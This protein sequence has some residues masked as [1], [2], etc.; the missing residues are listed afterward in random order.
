MVIY[1]KAYAT[2]KSYIAHLPSGGEMDIP[3]ETTVNEVLTMLKVPVELDK[4]IIV[5][6]RHQPLDYTLRHGDRLVFFPLI[7][8]G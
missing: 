6:N 3:E 2:M 5:N 7:Q 1:I 4:I 8:G